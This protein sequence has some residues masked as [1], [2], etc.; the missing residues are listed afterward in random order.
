MKERDEAESGV[1]TLILF[2]WS[3]YEILN[4]SQV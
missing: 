2:D 4:G 1:I 3:K